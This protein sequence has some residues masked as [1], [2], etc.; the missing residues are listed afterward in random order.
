LLKPVDE[1]DLQQAIARAIE[2]DR[3]TQ[4]YQHR[5]AVLAWR[6]QTLTPRERQVMALIVT[7]LLNK[8]IAGALGTSEKTVKIHRARVMQK[9]RAMSVAELVRMA[10][11]LGIGE[12]PTAPLQPLHV[13]G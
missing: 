8:Q 1:Q 5:R 7:G 2:E 10:D 3:Y 4:E 11:T 13:A 6:L 12:S 9:M